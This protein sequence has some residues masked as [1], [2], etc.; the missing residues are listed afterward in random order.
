MGQ[1][2][3]YSSQKPRQQRSKSREQAI[4]VPGGRR[5]ALD[6]ANKFIDD[7]QRSGFLQKSIER[8]GVI[9]ITAAGE[10]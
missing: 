6:A 8:S 5:D 9:G 4:I 2:L 3:L 7:V 1:G 10:R